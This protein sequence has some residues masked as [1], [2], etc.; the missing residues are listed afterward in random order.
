MASVPVP[1][2]TTNLQ[3]GVGD[4][5]DGTVLP[6]LTV[7]VD[8]TSITPKGTP[9]SI[10]IFSNTTPHH[11]V[12]SSDSASSSNY[13]GWGSA[14]AGRSD[15]TIAL[16]LSESIAPVLKANLEV[17]AVYMAPADESI[18]GVIS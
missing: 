5:I 10:G 12:R 6:S 18:T 3:G 2:L 15:S 11:R 16:L 17:A 9:L 14:L 4:H 1:S 7:P 13:G 8:E